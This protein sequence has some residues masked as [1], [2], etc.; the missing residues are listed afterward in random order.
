MG[1]YISK[2]LGQALIQHVGQVFPGTDEDLLKDRRRV[3][4]RQTRRERGV[5]ATRAC[6]ASSLIS[7]QR[8]S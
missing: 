5:T 4:Q 1:I 3:S 7:F 6:L 2:A 8:P